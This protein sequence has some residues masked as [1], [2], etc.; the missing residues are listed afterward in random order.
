MK[1]GKEKRIRGKERRKGM[2]GRRITKETNKK[3]FIGQNRIVMR[4]RKNELRRKTRPNSWL[5]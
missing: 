3:V 1:A 4:K 2:D 5:K